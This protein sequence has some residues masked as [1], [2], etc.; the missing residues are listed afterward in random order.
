M[1]AIKGITC[2]VCGLLLLCLGGSGG[3]G[4][5]RQGKGDVR[6]LEIRVPVYGFCLI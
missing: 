4:A 1:S 3:G 5:T 2:D 6:G